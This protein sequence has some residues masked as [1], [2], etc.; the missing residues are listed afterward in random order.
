MLDAN[1]FDYV[2]DRGIEPRSVRELGEI[3]I[4]SVQHGELLAVP[5]P[6]RRKRLLA[7]LSTIDP[8]VRPGAADVRLDATFRD[9]RAVRH[10]A[11]ADATAAADRRSRGKRGRKDAAIGEV[12][13]LEG[14]VLVTDDR[15]FGDRAARLG[16]T[17]LSCA[18]AFSGL[19][20][21]G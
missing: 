7:V 5:D 4:T 19:P 17:V 8:I 12:A 6:R 16:V 10:V 18:D 3:F 21:A 11:P 13:L 1:A 14:C 20:S 2:L 15:E 9:G